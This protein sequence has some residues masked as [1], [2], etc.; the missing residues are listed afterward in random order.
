M[1]KTKID[2]LFIGE[3]VKEL[4]GWSANPKTIKECRDFIRSLIKE[5]QEMAE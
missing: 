5:L 4:F 3:K 1:K 2:E